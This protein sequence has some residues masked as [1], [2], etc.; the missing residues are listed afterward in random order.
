MQDILDKFNL[1]TRDAYAWLPGYKEEK[2][3]KIFG[4]LPM[5]V[6][7]E[8]I[9][10]AGALPVILQEGNEPITTGHSKIQSFFCG[11]ARSIVDLSLKGKMDFVDALVSPE[12]D[13]PINGIANVLRINMSIP[14]LTIYQPTTC[15]KEAS[16]VF[17]S[18]EIKRFKSSVEECTGQEI[19]E[20]RLKESIK[21]YNRNRALLR[22]LYDL[23]R[24]K[25]GLLSSIQI[26]SVVM[27]GMLMLKEEHNQLLE[28]LIVKLKT[29]EA[30]SKSKFR[31]V[32]SGS[33]CQAPVAD[34]L[35]LIEEAGAIIVDDDIYTGTRY[36][37]G[38]VG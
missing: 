35:H 5:Y 21:I 34:L 20:A 4:C 18:K 33:L 25:A 32:L 13:L 1:V 7:E 22:E 38:D 36:F 26:S 16:Q 2:G 27:A 11:I 19:T 23:R 37:A 30:T 31:I 15:S 24:V 3:L 8:I 29:R 9:H 28:T 14:S 12:I 6:P 10:A 17:L